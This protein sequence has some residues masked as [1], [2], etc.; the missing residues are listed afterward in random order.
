MYENWLLLL[1]ALMLP[2]CKLWKY[3]IVTKSGWVHND[4]LNMASYSALWYYSKESLDRVFGDPFRMLE[5]VQFALYW[6]IWGDDCNVHFANPSMV[7][8]FT[9]YYSLVLSLLFVHR[10]HWECLHNTISSSLISRSKTNS[11]SLLISVKIKRCSWDT[12]TL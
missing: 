9:V 5:C 1:S 2:I 10:Q 11:N 7:S 4:L 6:L 3:M 12:I 8:S